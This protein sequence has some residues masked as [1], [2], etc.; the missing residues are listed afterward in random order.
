[1]FKYNQYP[2]KAEKVSLALATHIKIEQVNSCLY[3]QRK[4]IKKK[5]RN[6]ELDEKQKIKI[7]NNKLLKRAFDVD[8][9]LEVHTELQKLKQKTKLSEIAIKT[10][11]KNRRYRAKKGQ[12]I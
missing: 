12:K 10:W 3:N 11:F 8:P 7:K 4:K 2:S 9:F 6:K 1:M 5:I